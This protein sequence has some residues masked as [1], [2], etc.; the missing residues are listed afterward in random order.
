MK[1]DI[2]LLGHVQAR[3]GGRAVELGAA[4]QRCV[5]VALVVEPGRPVS[6]D[7]L[8]H[9]VWGDRVPATARGTLRTY[10]T[11]LRKVFGGTDV[12]IVR[13]AGGYVF[14]V[15]AEAVDLHRFRDLVSRARFEGEHADAL[16]D[17]A[18]ALWNG[19]PFSGLDTPWINEV[20]DTVTGEHWAAQLDHADAR[21]RQGRHAELVT[22]LVAWSHD[23]PLDER[24]AGQ[25][26]L[27]LYR[28]G[29]QAEALEHYR[30][31]REQLAEELGVDPGPELRRLHQRIL[32]VDVALSE[33][34]TAAAL[35]QLPGAVPHFAGRAAELGVLTAWSETA[36][37]HPDTVSIM[38]VSGIPGVGKTCLA[39][40]WARRHSDR[41]PDGQLYVNLRGFDQDGTP[42]PPAQAV[43]GF[44]EAF[45][46]P[47]QKIPADPDAQA[48]L[49]RSLVEGKRMLVV[50]DNARDTEHV[51]ALLPRSPS[52][53]VLVTSRHQLT[54]L[55]VREQARQIT[56]DTLSP[57][58]ALDLLTAFL[59]ADRIAAEREAASELAVRC[60][61]L[62]LALSIAGARAQAVPGLPL[63]SLVAEMASQRLGALS[64][65]GPDTDLRSVFS[66]SY[67]ALPASAARL[68]RQLAAHPGPDIAVATAAALA[69]VTDAEARVA[70]AELAQANLVQQHKPGRYQL[71][72]LLRAYADEVARATD[73]DADRHAAA[74]RCQDY[75]LDTTQAAMSLVDP[76]AAQ[77][78][79]EMDR[80]AA[81]EWLDS[82]YRNLLASA[83]HG[84]PEHA[85]R[86]PVVLQYYF[87]IRGRV[88]DWLETHHAALAFADGDDKASATIHKNL[89]VAYWLTTHFDEALQHNE[90]ALA[91]FHR[92]G[93]LAGEG[94][95]LNLRGLIEER[96]GRYHDAI[97]YLREALELR[98]AT[99]ER[100]GPAVTLQNLGNVL[101]MVGRY[102]EAI[103]HYQR[104]LPIFRELGERR[105]VAI[106]LANTGMVQRRAGRYEEALES[107]RAATTFTEATDHWVAG[108]TMNGM[109]TVL[110]R[111]GRNEEALTHLLEA[112][113]LMRQVGDRA[114]ESAILNNLGV[115]HRAL[116]S[117][118]QALVHHRESLALAADAQHRHEEATAHDGIAQVI[119]ATE[120][121]SARDHWARA[122]A[123]YEELGAPETDEVRQSLAGLSGL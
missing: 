115:A 61:H 80:E 57:A 54:G 62:P 118:D 1:V 111:L 94:E 81:L 30:R 39:V 20:R 101:D 36:A 64:T 69:D 85:W 11:R 2:R 6:A 25:L 92:S 41:F 45:Q 60:G 10:L 79:V 24:L 83:A 27:A 84:T 34:A 63:A 74:I 16:F 122:L 98:F 52:C 42:M 21:L 49:Y 19:E 65:D 35:R 4:Q 53:L 14:E 59:G 120:P 102:D 121:E 89:A 40:A 75:Y 86:I 51:R 91:L 82:E 28:C 87:D 76:R 68:F 3:I 47:P 26:I 46:V 33:P 67:H 9:R 78:P 117:P 106:V 103:E 29:R 90:L 31:V 70:L 107:Y 37:R 48:A 18:L 108:N 50:L 99:G 7:Q 95:M 113:R 77:L 66:W 71:H 55:V 56:L 58:E 73:S 22:D 13:R 110:N 100:R 105:G 88:D 109:G 12:A 112:L 114:C 8:V 38:C 32:E 44:L 119:V 5:L 23:H 97:K 123:I 116:G 72:D 104:A 43:R 17:R 15:D 96:R 93:D